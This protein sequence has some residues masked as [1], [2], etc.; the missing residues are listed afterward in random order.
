MKPIGKFPRSVFSAHSSTRKGGNIRNFIVL[1]ILLAIITACN[2]TTDEKRTATASSTPARMVEQPTEISTVS[3]LTTET[4]APGP[5]VDTRI[6]PERWQEWPVV[7]T[8]RPEMKAI[9]QRG[10]ELGNNPGAFS[11]IGDGEIST[12]WFLTQY[13]L[14]PSYYHLG[15]YTYLQSVIRRFHGSFSHAG[16][17]AGRGFTTTIILQP[18]PAGTSECEAGESRLDCELRT[19]HPSFAFI[20]L[21]TN[22]VWQS[23]VFEPELRRIIVRLLESE[24]VPILATKADDLEGDQRINRIIAKLAYEYNL[25][26]WNFWLAVQGIPE[27]GLQA[28]HEHLTYA[29]S[30]FDI[31]VNFQSAWPWRNLTALQV[32]DH[33]ARSVSDQP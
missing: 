14:A 3:A 7:P 19:F 26:L 1:M 27:H 25:P 16:V 18:P 31:S 20:S 23:E 4:P 9:F 5:T 13:D 10:A 8:V 28:D 6:S 24:V 15:P 12:V 29:D 33:V 22:Q 30:N 11:K 17:A 2:A 21:G 32:L